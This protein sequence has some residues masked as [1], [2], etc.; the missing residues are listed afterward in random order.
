MDVYHEREK[1]G[2]SETPVHIRCVTTLETATK[3]TVSDCAASSGSH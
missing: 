3:R 2:F 1:T